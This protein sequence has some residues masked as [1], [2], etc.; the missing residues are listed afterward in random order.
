MRR[1][2][3]AILFSRDVE[4]PI[5]ANA[6]CFP[7]LGNLYFSWG[8]TP[9]LRPTSTS[10][11]SCSDLADSVGEE[12]V[13]EDPRRPGGLPHKSLAMPDVEK[14]RWHWPILAAAAFQAAGPAH[15]LASFRPLNERG[16]IRKPCVMIAR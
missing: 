4:Q 6:A 10:A 11:C 13:L 1:S 2:C 7:I 16:G 12:R 15:Q 9:V 3:I 8:R 5:L 14:N